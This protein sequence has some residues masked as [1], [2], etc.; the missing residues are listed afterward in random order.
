MA[1]SSP[2]KKKVG[3][4][5]EVLPTP[6]VSRLDVRFLQVLLLEGRSFAFIERT[7]QNHDL[8][9]RKSVV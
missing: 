3:V 1:K 7:L 4:A 5:V 8:P 6:R 9:D 2:K